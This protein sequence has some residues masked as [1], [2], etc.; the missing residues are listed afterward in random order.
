MEKN[1]KNSFASA[2]PEGR[3][4]NSLSYCGRWEDMVRWEGSRGGG[5]GQQ[6][7]ERSCSSLNMCTFFHRDPLAWWWRLEQN[8]L[9][10]SPCLFETGAPHHYNVLSSASHTVQVLLVNS[11]AIPYSTTQIYS[12]WGCECSGSYAAVFWKCSACFGFNKKHTSWIVSQKDS[13]WILN[14]LSMPATVLLDL[15]P[16]FDCGTF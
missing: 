8:V 5:R 13:L 9:F 14:L 16:A 4:V 7:R 3:C 11:C 2:V 15:S 12:V 6:L 10:F 1:S